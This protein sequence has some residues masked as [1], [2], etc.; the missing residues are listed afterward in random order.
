MEKKY[1]NE[2]KYQKNAKTLKI[3]GRIVLAIGIIAMIAGI[4]FIILGFSG[5]GGSIVS[6]IDGKTGQITNSSMMKDVFGGMGLFALG[7]LLNV[8]GL[9]ITGFGA[10][11]LVIAHK[12]EIM[13]FT[14][15]QTIPVAKEVAEDV[16]P[17]VGNVAKEIT[18]GVKEGMKDE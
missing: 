11:I 1:L 16:A 8:F 10:V 4:V 3:I 9:G 15:Q 17:T 2:E 7:G 18:K 14:A 6:G 12:R 5:F 13:A